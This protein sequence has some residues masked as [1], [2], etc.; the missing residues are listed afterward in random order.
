MSAAAIEV[1]F[2][3]RPP[4]RAVTNNT[5]VSCT[6]CDTSVIRHCRSANGIEIVNG[7]AVM[8]Q[9]VSDQGMIFFSG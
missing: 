4:H 1:S 7:E 2:F 3:C 9:A 8:A 6:R 5:T